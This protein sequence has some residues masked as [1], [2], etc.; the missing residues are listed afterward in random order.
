M[1]YA[2]SSAILMR[3]VQKQNECETLRLQHYLKIIDKHSRIAE[4]NNSRMIRHVGRNIRE[5]NLRSGGPPEIVK[6]DVSEQHKSREERQKEEQHLKMMAFLGSFS[7]RSSAKGRN[8]AIKQTS[9]FKKPSNLEKLSHKPTS[10]AFHKE[11]DL[12]YDAC[13]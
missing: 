11:H 5:L 13:Q 3:R 9:I 8:N 6:P 7:N 10:D 4:V 1:S 12:A 2:D